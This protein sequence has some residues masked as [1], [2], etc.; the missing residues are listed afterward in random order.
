MDALPA[1]IH[2]IAVFRDQANGVPVLLNIFNILVFMD[3][4]W[5]FA[6]G[7]GEDGIFMAM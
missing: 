1:E 6:R 4:F 7:A 2:L 5:I 3:L